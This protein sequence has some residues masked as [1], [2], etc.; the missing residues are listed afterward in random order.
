MTAERD[1]TR[2]V[3][4]W[5]RLD[6]HDSADRVLENV[7]ASLD[8]T[9]QRRSW[10]PARRIADMNK[11][12]PLAAA[13]AALLVVAVVGYN[14]LR[15]TNVGPPLQQVARETNRHNGRCCRQGFR[16]DQF[17]GQRARFFAQQDGQ[18]VNAH[19]SG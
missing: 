14:L 5:L 10:W 16:F 6:E 13:A 9:P 7:L 17:S 4:S 11:L 15:S 8:A 3:R 19:L 12:L 1:V 18:P 2:V